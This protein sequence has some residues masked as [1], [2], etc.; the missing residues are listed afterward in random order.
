M[1]FK[2]I[3]TQEQFDEAIKD[4]LVRE[5]KKYEG[6]MSPEDVAKLNDDFSKKIEEL[7]KSST[8]YASQIDSLNKSIQEK[9]DQIKKYETNS[10][11]MRICLNNGLPFEMA[12]RLTG[13]TEEEIQKD[14]EQLAKL[15]SVNIKGSLNIAPQASTTKTSAED[16]VTKI[17]KEMNPNLEL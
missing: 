17:F 2:K 12:S 4:R 5:A 14:A 3:E 15:M 1:E 10:V 7:N 8:D 13:T 11:K 6:Y 16:G 9:D